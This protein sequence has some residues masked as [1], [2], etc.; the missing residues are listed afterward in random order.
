[1]STKPAKL[2]PGT[3]APIPDE[4][5]QVTRAI[6]RC[7]LEV[8]SILG[9]GLLER[10][11]EDALCYELTQAGLPI[12]RQPSVRVRYKTIELSEQRLDI[13]VASLVVVELKAVETVP[14]VYLSQ[15]VSY[16]RS[17]DLPLGLLINFNV[18]RLKDGLY[19]RINPHS[20]A[21]R[22]LPLPR[23]LPLGHSGSSGPS[24]F[25]F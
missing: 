7:A 10:L 19:R 15:L 17:A 1:M 6:I 3:F 2:P 18:H 24:E 16:L 8:H 9:P 25:D 14:D 4:W 20:S 23:G 11:Y 12:V 22:A 5:N 21:I 13:V